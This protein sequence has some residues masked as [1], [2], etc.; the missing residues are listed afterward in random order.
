MADMALGLF[1]DYA[2]LGQRAFTKWRS[3]AT[4]I[5][6]QDSWRPRANLTI[7]GGFRYVIWPPWHSTTNNIANF[8]PAS[9]IPTSRR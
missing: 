3:L 9:T 6:L 2:E 7:E 4:D 1:T 8:D 5:F